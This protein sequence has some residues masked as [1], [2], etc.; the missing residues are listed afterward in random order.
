MTPV[1]PIA[2]G[3][4][5]GPA[6]LRAGVAGDHLSSLGPLGIVATLP[7]RWPDS[8]LEDETGYWLLF[9]IVILMMVAAIQPRGGGKA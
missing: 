8:R 5:L 1:S 4:A 6:V 2:D 7:G 9:A 3:N